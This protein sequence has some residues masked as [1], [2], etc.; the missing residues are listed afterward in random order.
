VEQLLSINTTKNLI[1][2]RL[3]DLHHIDRSICAGGEWA[4]IATPSQCPPMRHI[5]CKAIR[6]CSEREFCADAN[7][8]IGGSVVKTAPLGRLATQVRCL[9]PGFRVSTS[10]WRRASSSAKT[11]CSTL[12]PTGTPSSVDRG[13]PIKAVDR[14]FEQD[15]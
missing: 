6:S 1:H 4:H 9:Q 5:T 12:K 13:Q 10:H 7:S 3:V 8:N 14:K 2:N 11:L 15:I